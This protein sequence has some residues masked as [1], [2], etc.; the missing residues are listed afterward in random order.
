MALIT[1]EVLMLQNRY[2]RAEASLM[3]MISKDQAR[4]S[5]STYRKTVLKS[6]LEELL[7]LDKYAQDW[8]EDSIPK[9]YMSGTE[10]TYRAFRKAQ[11]AVGTVAVNHKVI[12][13]LVQNAAGSLKDASAFVGRRVYDDIREVT[14]EAITSKIAT[15][16]TVAEAKK[17]LL[18]KYARSGI[19]EVKDKNGRP[20]KLESYA[21]MVAR[22]TTAEAT[23]K[24][25]MQTMKDL[26]RD[27][28]RM[29]SHFSSCPICVVYEGRVYSMSGRDPDYPALSEA[30]DGYGTIHPNCTHRLVPYIKEFD[31]DAEKTQKDSMRP[32]EIDPKKKASIDDYNKQQAIKTARRN[33]RNEWEKAKLTAPKETPKTFSAFRSIK[34]ADG[35][36][37]AS[38][39]ASIK[40]SMPKTATSTKIY[41]RRTAWKGATMSNN[42]S[43]LLDKYKY[44]EDEASETW[45]QEKIIVAKEKIKTK[46]F[47]ENKA[48]YFNKETAYF[49][50]PIQINARFIKDNTFGG[51]NNERIN[52]DKVERLMISIKEKGYDLKEPITVMVDATGRA[53]IFEGNHRLEAVNRLGIKSIPTRVSYYD[54]AERADGVWKPDSL[55]EYL[56]E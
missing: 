43:P 13:G 27:L 47:R 32:F 48:T 33:D 39:Q 37:Y 9:A 22:T 56:Q 21:T 55:V 10:S 51:L 1:R 31:D 19:L 18:E 3:D 54:G 34:K 41:G 46:D 14:L 24:G 16:S 29:T 7:L 50:D 28:V 6:V 20:M 35:D 44:I 30:F 2:K 38:I 15:G 26:G 25:T 53:F 12:D 45:I 36:K 23:N 17:L 40:A 49:E 42:N 4:G 5:L 8:A 11:V 52:V